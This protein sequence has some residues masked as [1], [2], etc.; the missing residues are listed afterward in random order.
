MPLF[1]RVCSSCAWSE[2]DVW[3]PVYV[4]PPPSCPQCGAATARAWLTK[5]PAV[6]GDEMDHLQVNGLATPRRFRSK[7]EHKRWQKESGWVVK[8]THVAPN[9]SDRSKFTTDWSRSYDPFTAN[10]VRILLERAFHQAPKTEED[11]TIHF[12]PE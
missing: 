11:D 3:E 6:V 7:Q 10:N 2:V 12:Q 1:D 8:D 4:D 9:G 5:P